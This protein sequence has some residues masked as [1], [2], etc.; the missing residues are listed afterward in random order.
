MVQAGLLRNPTLGLD[1]GFRLNN[2]KTDEL[3]VSLVQDF[4]DLF[5]LPLR[6]QIAREESEAATLNVANRV[7][8]V[9]V[10]TE[11]AFVV[12][13]AVKGTLGAIMRGGGVDR[14]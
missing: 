8:E 14:R 5:V 13:Q 2:G 6:K 11:K 3:R 9:A 1:L 12:A 4:L 10:E 7:L